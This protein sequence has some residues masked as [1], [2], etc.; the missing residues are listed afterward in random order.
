[1][2]NSKIN[3][4]KYS[5]REKDI[6]SVYDNNILTGLP[7][8]THCIEIKS[9]EL[10]KKAVYTQMTRFELM[11]IKKIITDILEERERNGK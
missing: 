8:L 10:L 9:N 4:T 7:D 3:I 2:E 1:M 11:Q 5:K 6:I